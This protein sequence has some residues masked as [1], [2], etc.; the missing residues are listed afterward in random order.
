VREYGSSD[1]RCDAIVVF[2]P[3][4]RADLDHLDRRGR[5][6]LL[7]EQT[8][9]LVQQM[10]D[11]LRAAGLADEV[12]LVDGKAEDPVP[13]GTV[14]VRATPSSLAKVQN[15]PYVAAV[16]DIDTPLPIWPLSV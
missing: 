9:H 8:R 13:A 10:L 16:A 5:A 15:L 7:R 3:L 1:E 14:L 4:N 2:A 11:D 6:S 12:V